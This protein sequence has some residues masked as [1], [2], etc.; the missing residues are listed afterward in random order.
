MRGPLFRT[1][2]THLPKARAQQEHMEPKVK[3]LSQGLNFLYTHLRESDVSARIINQT[4]RLSVFPERSLISALRKIWLKSLIHGQMEISFA[5][6][7]GNPNCPNAG[8][9]A[10][11]PI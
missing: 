5:R 2:L 9:G 3:L 10:L 11:L 4:D 7:A 1:R 8:R 6:I